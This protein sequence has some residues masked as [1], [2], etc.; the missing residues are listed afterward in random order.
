M[1]YATIVLHNFGLNHSINY[2]CV[3]SGQVSCKYSA[4]MSVITYSRQILVHALLLQSF[5]SRANQRALIK[6]NTAESL[7][8]SWEINRARESNSLCRTTHRRSA[9]PIESTLAAAFGSDVH[10]SPR[11]Y[12][13]HFSLSYSIYPLVHLWKVQTPKEEK[14][15]KRETGETAFG[16]W[17]EDATVGDPV[18]H[19]TLCQDL[20]WNGD[21]VWAFR[22]G[23]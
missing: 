8:S 10:L 15:T 14:K 4:S 16:A 11:G 23:C 13:A 18:E 22:Y 1:V 6:M 3:Q 20:N 7:L 5:W 17:H 19:G 21:Q 2:T 9:R 12:T